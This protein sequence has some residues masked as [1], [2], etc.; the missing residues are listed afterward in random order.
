V[1]YHGS[2]PN[3]QLPQVLNGMLDVLFAFSIA[4]ERKGLLS[5]GEIVAV[6]EAVKAQTTEWT[7]GT[8]PARA[9]IADLMI[10]A[11]EIPVAGE[12][13]RQ[14]WQVVDGGKP[15]AAAPG[16]EHLPPPA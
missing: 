10:Q 6:L 15:A 2:V 7:G 14:S 4:L 11:F 8:T 5:R 3:E 13:V 16:D 12:Q 1:E 9:L